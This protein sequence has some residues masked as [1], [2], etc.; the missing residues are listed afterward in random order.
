MLLIVGLVVE[1][2]LSIVLLQ[3]RLE[4]NQCLIITLAR[5][6]MKKSGIEDGGIERQE[7]PRQTTVFALD[8]L[9]LHEYS[10]AKALQ[11][12]SKY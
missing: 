6:A 7:G 10:Q 2:Q 5:H 12:T 9:L 1:N 8:H 3:Y 11:L 4:L